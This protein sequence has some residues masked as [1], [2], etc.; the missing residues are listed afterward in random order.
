MVI[1]ETDGYKYLQN[2]AYLVSGW[3]IVHADGMQKQ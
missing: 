3:C 1:P 2:I